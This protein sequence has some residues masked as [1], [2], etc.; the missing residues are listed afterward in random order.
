MNFDRT[1]VNKKVC[2]WAGVAVLALAVSGC[3]A[4]YRVIPVLPDKPLTAKLNSVTVEPLSDSKGQSLQGQYSRPKF[5]V[6]VKNNTQQAIKFSTENIQATLNGEP[7]KV[8]TF[9]AQVDELL[10]VLRVSSGSYSG[11]YPSLRFSFGSFGRIGSGVEF[12]SIDIQ[13]TQQELYDVRKNALRPTVLDPGMEY[14]G[15]ITLRNKLPAQRD[16]DIRL[17]VELAGETQSFQFAL[18]QLSR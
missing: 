12:D 11:F 7:A 1:H 4:P 3:A 18:Q 10:N 2:L 16:Q 9:D 15:E 6:T 17:T 8:M 14:S 5:K 13:R